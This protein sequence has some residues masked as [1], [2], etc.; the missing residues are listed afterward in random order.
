MKYILPHIKLGSTSFLLHDTYVPALR[1]AA[2]HCE[3]IALLMIEV[4][5]DGEHLATQEEIYES[6]AI[7]EE[8]NTS[9]HVHLPTEASCDTYASTQSLIKACHL[10]I[11]RT[12]SLSPHTFVIHLDFPSICGAE[13]KLSL[14]Q[15]NLN[16][17][18]KKLSCEQEEWT[19]EALHAIAKALPAPDYLAIEN[20]EG[21]SP[22]FWDRWITNTAYSRCYDIG[23]MWKDGRNPAPI[24]IEWLPKIRIIHL[25]GLRG[26][27]GLKKHSTCDAKKYSSLCNAIN[28]EA[29]NYQLETWAQLFG[30]HPKD[31]TTLEHM[32]PACIDAIMHPLWQHNFAG[33]LNL[34]LFS[35]ENFVASHAVLMQSWERYNKAAR[36]NEFEA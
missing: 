8:T 18:Q 4:G 5:K 14:A 2:Q 16:L 10:V 9:L 26:L 27:H 31:H 33:V 24:L 29:T 3:D 28:P 34:E 23:H 32:P 22:T 30:A 19:A 13:H 1:F 20:L 15:E 36:Q 7:L 6:K 35:F 17:E 11:E 25:H 21:Y 12:K